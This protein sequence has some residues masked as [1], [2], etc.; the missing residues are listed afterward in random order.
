MKEIHIIH[1]VESNVRHDW[2]EKLIVFI[3]EKGLSQTLITIESPGEINDY[4]ATK[5][6]NLDINSS[7]KN[8]SLGILGGVREIIKARKKNSTNIVL[9]FG[10][11]AAFITGVS[12]YFTKIHFVFSHM[13]QPRY[14]KL[15]S[16]SWK[17]SFHSLA[18]KF[19][20]RRAGMIFSLS[21][22]VGEFLGIAG[23]DR[24]KIVSIN[25]GINFGK[26]RQ[27]QSVID[28]PVLTIDGDPKILMVGRIA[29]EKNYILALQTLSLF[30][31]FHPKAVLA[32]AGDGPQK[33]EI[34]ELAKSLGIRNH[35][36]FLG[37]VKNIPNLMPKF[38]L[39]LHLASTE[40]YGQ[41]YIESLLSG[42]PV[43]C[44]RTGIAID[45]TENN[46]PNI[47]LV[48]TLL[49]EI[50]NNELLKYFNKYNRPRTIQSNLFNHFFEHEDTYVYQ[51]IV[52]CLQIFETKD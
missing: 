18:Y 43:L 35:V 8:H 48:S 12:T 11:P 20:I 10:H 15:M 37:F 22:E 29:P 51:D 52:R 30:L 41:I 38:D 31:K 32:I 39:L 23:V 40:S 36:Q 9:A 25:I 46:E 13:Q 14:F 28:E 42:L 50:I 33:K 6:P 17:G 26:I 1:F 3:N 16:P 7:R 2:L 34:L 21:R 5:Y 49:P 27:Q 47:N 45:L 19:Y 24:S 44:S 4:L